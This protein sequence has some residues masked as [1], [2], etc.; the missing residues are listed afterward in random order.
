MSTSVTE[1]VTLGSWKVFELFMKDLS[2]ADR[3]QLFFNASGEPLPE[4]FS[5]NRLEE[6]TAFLSFP[7]PPLRHFQ[8][9]IFFL[10]R[11]RA[12]RQDG[13]TTYELVGPCIQFTPPGRIITNLETGSG[14]DDVA[15][16]FLMVDAAFLVAAGQ[17]NL[18]PELRPFQP[19]QSP[20][21]VPAAADF[22][23]LDALLDGLC[24]EYRRTGPEQTRILAA[25]LSVFLLKV[26]ARTAQPDAATPA[27]RPSAAEQ[28]TTRFRQLVAR[29]VLARRSVRD[30]AEL[31]CVTPDHLSRCV[32]ETT[33]RPAREL[34]ADML[35]LEAKVLLRQTDLSVAEVAFRLRFEDASYFG[36]W[37]RK[38]V[39]QTP[40]AYR[41][42]H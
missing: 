17:P 40:A 23:E 28:L 11:G 35:L 20:V 15:G 21:W 36:R 30:Y 25:L 24:Q 7:L 1:V 41:Q 39:G 26:K 42:A 33:G 8:Y 34:I 27:F 4:G 13:L 22:A 14:I 10:R 12:L 31:L 6:N 19:D 16:Y 3:Q 32:R 38:R 5:I 18:L 9:D 29:H 37:F 2:A